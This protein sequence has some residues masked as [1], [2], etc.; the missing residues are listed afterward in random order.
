MRAAG[1]ANVRGITVAFEGRAAFAQSVCMMGAEEAEAMRAYSSKMVT[2]FATIDERIPTTVTGEV[3]ADT[4]EVI[5][6]EVDR[7]EVW[8]REMAVPWDTEGG[9]LDSVRWKCALSPVITVWR[10]DYGARIAPKPAVPWL[11]YTVTASCVCVASL[12]AVSA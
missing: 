8:R 4:F 7:M 3:R 9:L 1:Q 2:F 6:E 5:L 11:G 12:S 10:A